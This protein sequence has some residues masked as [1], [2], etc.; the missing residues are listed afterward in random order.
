M[1]AKK[2]DG[3]DMYFVA[4]IWE[5]AELIKLCQVECFL[6]QAPQLCLTVYRLMIGESQLGNIH[7]IIIFNCYNN[8]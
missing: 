1:Q 3:G 5:E 6:E 8:K 7:C 2:K 4:M